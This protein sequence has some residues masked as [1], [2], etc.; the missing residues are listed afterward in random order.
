[1]TYTIRYRT[2]PTGVDHQAEFQGDDQ[3]QA[4][5][6]AIRSLRAHHPY[7]VILGVTP[8]SIP[9]PPKAPCHICG[10][11][12]SEGFTHDACRRAQDF[13]QRAYS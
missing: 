10:G 11:E 3:T 5:E 2:H 6:T 9:S 8:V 1:M 12:T 7:A 13:E 4:T